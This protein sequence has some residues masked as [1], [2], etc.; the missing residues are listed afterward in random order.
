M[1]GGGDKRWNK[2]KQVSQVKSN[3]CQASFSTKRTFGAPTA[4]T[5]KKRRKNHVPLK[6]GTGEEKMKQFWKV[7]GHAF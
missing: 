3:E 6:R 1:W 4:E 2:I 5:P 7:P